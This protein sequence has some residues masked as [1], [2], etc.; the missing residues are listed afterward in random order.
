M[1]I[2]DKSQKSNVEVHR[3]KGVELYE[4]GWGQKYIAQA[5]GVTQGVISQWVKKVNEGGKDALKTKFSTGRPSCLTEEQKNQLPKLLEKG[6]EYYGFV[7][8][9][10]TQERIAK[11]IEVEFG[12]KCHYTTAGRIIRSLNWSLQK[13]ETKAIQRKEEE[14]KDWKEKKWPELKKKQKRKIER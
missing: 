7:G 2:E 9:I 1:K 12:V 6:A 14:I 4:A 5:L 3:H 11:V 13:P 8:E 10:W